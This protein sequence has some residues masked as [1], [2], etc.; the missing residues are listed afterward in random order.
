M[1]AIIGLIVTL[2]TVFGGFLLAGGKMD[3]ILHSLPFEGLSICGAAIGAFIVGN[4]S[5]AIK[6]TI[7]DLG[8]MM[9]GPKWKSEDYNDLLCLLFEIVRLARQNPM[10]LEEHIE[11]PENSDIFQRYPKVLNDHIALDMICDTFR[12]SGMNFDDPHQVGD[13]L[14]ADL[15]KQEEEAM[16]SSHAL[17]NMADALPALGIVAAVLGIIKT[18]S[19]IDQPP[20]ILGG[21]IGAALVGTFLGVFLAYGVVGPFATKIGAINQEEQNYYKLIRDV[22]VAYLYEHQPTICI[23]VGRKSTPHKFRPTF[24]DLET[25]L[26][27]LKAAA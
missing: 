7:G 11:D 25:S 21:M 13:M 18:M 14:E 12:S 20:E 22:L 17:Q 19:S 4:D 8:K 26:R 16:H 2:A 23:E 10:G 15:M 9:K 1:G 5:A 24:I 3:I 27:E 6:H